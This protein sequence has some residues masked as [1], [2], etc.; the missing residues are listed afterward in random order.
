MLM[1]YEKLN[2]LTISEK[3]EASCFWKGTVLLEEQYR[4]ILSV[5][6]VKDM[7]RVFRTRCLEEGPVKCLEAL[8]HWKGLC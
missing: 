8:M 7:H 6:N 1:K 3:W 4:E 2:I 5:V